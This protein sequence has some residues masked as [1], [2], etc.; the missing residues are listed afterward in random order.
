MGP[1]LEQEGAR[2]NMSPCSLAEWGELVPY[3]VRVEAGLGVPPKG[4]LRWLAHTFGGVECR[5]HVEVPCFCSRHPV[6]CSGLFRSGSWSFCSFCI[7]FSIICPNCPCT[8]LFLVPY[9]FFTFCCWRR[10][11][12]KCKHYSKDSQVKGPR[13][14][15]TPSP[16]AVPILAMIP[17]LVQ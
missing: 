8:Q 9:S 2:T 14:E 1:L 17:S 12:S 13:L 7:L 11:L 16:R 15:K 5:G 4:W 3:G 10:C 6:F